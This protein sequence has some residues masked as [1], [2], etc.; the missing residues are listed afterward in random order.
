[1]GLR[2]PEQFSQTVAAQTRYHYLA[3]IA[4]T[5]VLC[6]VLA[7]VE[8]RVSLAARTKRLLLGAWVTW[9][10]TNA[11]FLLPP[12]DCHESDRATVAAA[13]DAMAAEIHA[14]PAG[15]TVCLPNRPVPLA[16]GFPGSVG[17]FILFERENT[18]DGR[19]VYFVSSDPAL[20][21]QRETGGRLAS[22]LV[23]AG[24]CPPRGD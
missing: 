18:V 1:M 3:Q 9:A 23:P 13:R 21:A 19:R 7:E 15:S 24:A 2:S 14:H 11:V 6:L 4:L 16:V 8:R 17:V 20:L 12:L 22:L 10:V 5:A